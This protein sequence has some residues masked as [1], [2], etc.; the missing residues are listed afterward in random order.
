MIFKKIFLSENGVKIGD[1]GLA[2]KYQKGLKMKAEMIGTW[3][4]L[5]PEIIR[6]QSYDEKIDI[7]SLG[8]IFYELVMD[9]HLS[10][11]GLSF[12]EQMVNGVFDPFLLERELNQKINGGVKKKSFFFFFLI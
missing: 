12:G 3:Q 4:F 7:F 8:C 11:L 10:E 2:S 6:K 5:A 1:F 9:V